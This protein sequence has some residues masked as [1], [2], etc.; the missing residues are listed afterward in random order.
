MNFFQLYTVTDNKAPNNNNNM[1]FTSIFNMRTGM[2]TPEYEFRFNNNNNIL[3]YNCPSA[4]VDTKCKFTD[5]PLTHLQE[6]WKKE[7]ASL[8]FKISDCLTVTFNPN[9]VSWPVQMEFASS[10]K[11]LSETYQYRGPVIYQTRYYDIQC[12]NHRQL[13]IVALQNTQRQNNLNSNFRNTKLMLIS[14]FR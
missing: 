2:R 12:S 9:F 10:E 8:Q 11:T 7:F 3:F 5:F 6:H 13:W 14:L 4:C 1:N